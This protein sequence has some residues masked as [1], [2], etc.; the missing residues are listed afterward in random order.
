MKLSRQLPLNA[1]RVFEAVARLQSFTRAGEELGMTQTAVSYQIKL[2]EDHVGEALFLRQSRQISLT[3]TGQRMQPKVTEAF[4][5]LTD[6]VATAR[7]AGQ[8]TLEIHA[9]PT[10]ASQWLARHLGSFQLAHPEIAVRLLRIG[11]TTD[12]RNTTA[13]VS[14]FWDV[15]ERPELVYV[16]LVDPPYGPILSPALA[17]SIGGVNTPADLLRLPL[18]S[19]HHI[20]WREWFAAAGI[21][22]PD[23]PQSGHDAFESQDLEVKAAIAGHGVAVV[24]PF[25]FPDE[26]ASGRLLL[27]FPE[28]AI[29]GK[30]IRLVYPRARR[31]LA[32]IR[33]F[34]SWILALMAEETA[35]RTGCGA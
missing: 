13:D 10:F 17:Q 20:T 2:L 16:D 29:R 6:A 22:E 1:M 35:S 24:S 27:P 33:A 4:D 5:L 7:K 23:L 30:P 31:N 11:K 28:I 19:P 12:F 3:D 26:L 34:Q 14:I 15:V 9:I 25:F 32:K 21:A 8:Q 18:M